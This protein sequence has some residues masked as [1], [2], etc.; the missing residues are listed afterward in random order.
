MLPGGIE[1]QL[2]AAAQFIEPDG[3]EGAD[4]REAGGQGK[5]QGHELIAERGTA[6]QNADDGIDKADEDDVGRHGTEVVEATSQHIHEIGWRDRSNHGQCG[7][8]L[9]R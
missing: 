6:K 1:A 3:G 7:R 9:G 4:Q 5:Q 8:W 2:A